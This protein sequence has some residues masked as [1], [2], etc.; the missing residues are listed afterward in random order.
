MV[1]YETISG[2]LLFRKYY[3]VTVFT[4]VL[5]GER[6]SRTA[7]FTDSLWKVLEWCWDRRPDT[8]PSIEDVLQ[9]LQQEKALPLPGP[10]AEME[11]WSGDEWD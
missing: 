5:K 10:D 4:K 6:P 1:I 9:C 3:T 8:R 7:S 2:R 11:E